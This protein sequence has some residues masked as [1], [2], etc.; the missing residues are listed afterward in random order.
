[1][2][3]RPQNREQLAAGLALLARHAEKLPL[4]GEIVFADGRAVAWK[5]LHAA[6]DSAPGTRVLAKGLD[7]VA[8]VAPD[9]LIATL[10]GQAWLN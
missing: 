9:D 8:L 5:E 10:E 4:D 2:L 3:L 6:F 1:M 7:R